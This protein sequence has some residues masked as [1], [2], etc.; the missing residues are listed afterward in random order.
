M[1]TVSVLVGNSDDKLSQKQWRSFV[2][3]IGGVINFLAGQIHFASGSDSHA[4]WQNFC[5]VFEI[6]DKD[7]DSLS[8][9]ITAIR[10][11]FEQDSV[12]IVIGDTKF[13]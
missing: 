9:N 6:Q 12:A 8:S 4:E 7:I 2:L 10:K 11:N 3:Q 5:W 13:I 1:K